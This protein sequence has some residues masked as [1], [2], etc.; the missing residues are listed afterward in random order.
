MKALRSFSA[1]CFAFVFFSITSFAEEEKGPLLRMDFSGTANDPGWVLKLDT[2]A[3]YRFNQHLEI[4]AGVP[5][6]F[7]RASDSGTIEDFTSKNGIGNVYV[8]FTLLFSWSALNFSSSIRGAAPT[9]NE[10]NGFSTGRVTVDWSNSI[11]GDIGKW[12][13]FVSLG[14]ANTIS[15]TQFFNR[16][17]TSLGSVGL[18]EGGTYFWASD[19]IG[20]GGSVYA[21]EPWGQQKIYSRLVQRQSPQSAAS[22]GKGN[23]HRRV[24]EE[25]SYTLSDAD[26]A[27]DHGASVWIDIDPISNVSLEVGFSR[28]ISYEYNSLFFSFHFDF[29]KFLSK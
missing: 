16:P 17:F 27:K 21:V 1:L 29:D 4:S 12:T 5:V 20:L 7:V 3:G 13:P 28:S 24:F 18:F 6:Y 2:S 10:E 19:L 26:M 11:D 9:G 22:P 23:S 14:I 15:D 25:G 8:D